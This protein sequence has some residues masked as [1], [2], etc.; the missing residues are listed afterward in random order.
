[1]PTDT[2]CQEDLLSGHQ[3]YRPLVLHKGHVEGHHLSGLVLQTLSFGL[4]LV[5]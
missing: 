3:G 5:S 2:S 4:E 1:M